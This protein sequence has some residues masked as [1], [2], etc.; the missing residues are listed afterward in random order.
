MPNWPDVSDNLME[1]NKLNKFY[2]FIR[3]LAV[4]SKVNWEASTK[5]IR[6]GLRPVA[7]NNKKYLGWGVSE[8]QSKNRIGTFCFRYFRALSTERHAWRP[9]A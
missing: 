1:N 7:K 6:P 5:S 4:R 8:S 2:G 3:H 9:I